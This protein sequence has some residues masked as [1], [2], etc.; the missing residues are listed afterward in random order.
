V[1]VTHDLALV[2]EL[3]LRAMP[4]GVRRLPLRGLRIVRTLAVISRRGQ[5]LSPAAAT[6]QAAL[7]GS[8]GTRRP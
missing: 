4:R 8:A 3:G 6:F 5:A 1:A 7:L 2:S